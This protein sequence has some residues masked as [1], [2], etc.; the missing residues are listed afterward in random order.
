MAAGRQRDLDGAISQFRVAIN[1][2]PTY[3]MAHYQLARALAQ[4]GQKKE[5]DWE[6]QRAAE[7]DRHLQSAR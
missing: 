2:M 1:S 5:S 3:A 4:K 7:L 6:F